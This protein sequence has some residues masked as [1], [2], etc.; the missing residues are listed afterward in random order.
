MIPTG[1]I[2]TDHRGSRTLLKLS[3]GQCDGFRGIPKISMMST[4]NGVRTFSSY[5]VTKEPGNEG[6]G[7]PWYS[8]SQP[9]WLSPSHRRRPGV[10]LHRG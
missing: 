6:K 1:M 5:R 3:R 8:C 10:R 4:V 9:S 7:V 2:S